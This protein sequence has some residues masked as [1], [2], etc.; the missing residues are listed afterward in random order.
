MTRL[1]AHYQPSL[2]LARIALEGAGV[3]DAVGAST[4]PAYFVPMWRVWEAA[5]ASALRDAGIQHVHEQP[6]FADRFVQQ[7][8]YP[9]L[10]VTL[11]PDLLIGYRGTPAL[12][13]DLKW[14]PALELRYGKKRLRNQHLYQLATY[15]AALRCDG[16]LVYPEMEDQIDSMYEFNGRTIRI[17]T[18]N[19]A[20]PSLADL[21]SFAVNLA[22]K[23]A[24]PGMRAG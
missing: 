4:A 5:V 24:E 21:R 23:M 8:G 10:R 1:N 20:T 13:I 6:E 7:G 14:A 17:R 9:K 2:R 11:R 18:V 16:L 12:A 22:E 19:L 15:C 3:H